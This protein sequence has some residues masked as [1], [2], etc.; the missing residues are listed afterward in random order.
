VGV[1]PAPV[2]VDPAPVGVDPA[3][4]GVD[5]APVGVDPAPV[6]VD[7]EAYGI[8]DLL[9]DMFQPPACRGCDCGPRVARLEAEVR[10]LQARLPKKVV[11][12]T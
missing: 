3:P 7:P 11:P 9:L 10:E 2:G 8:E 6:G 4:V 5:P 12:P 1:D